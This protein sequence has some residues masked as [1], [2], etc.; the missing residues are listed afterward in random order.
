MAPIRI[1]RKNCTADEKEPVKKKGTGPVP[2]PSPS[3]TI[4]YR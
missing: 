1:Y 2:V 3:R 4:N